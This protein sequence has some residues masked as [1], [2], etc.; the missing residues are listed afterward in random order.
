MKKRY[1]QFLLTFLLGAVLF[2][3]SFALD[4]AI[5]LAIR[6][7]GVILALFSATLLIKGNE[8]APPPVN[9]DYKYAVKQSI[10]SSAEQKLFSLLRASVGREFEVFPQVALVSIVD[11]LTA[12]AYRNELFRI[13]DFVL[14]DRRTYKLLLVIE[15]NDASHNKKER[16]ERDEKVKC[17][18]SRAGVKILTLTIENFQTVNL[19]HEV[20]SALGR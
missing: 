7:I 14:A 10:M 3:V 13:V 8:S 4:C 2:A 18:L 19:R 12:G 6:V 15:L 9:P 16:A 20:F 17:I 1:F 5:A 11:K